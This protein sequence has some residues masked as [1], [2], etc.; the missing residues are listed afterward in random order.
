MRGFAC[1]GKHAVVYES[2]A[3]AW[4]TRQCE[5]IRGVTRGFLLSAAG[6]E[7]A[8]LWPRGGEGGSEFLVPEVV[9]ALIREGKMEVE[10]LHGSGQCYGITYP[11]DRKRVAERIA[12]MTR[13]GRYPEGLWS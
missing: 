6:A 7:P 3:Q 9:Q 4:L 2:A 1:P 11:E 8:A 13:E 10:V 5:S 12:E